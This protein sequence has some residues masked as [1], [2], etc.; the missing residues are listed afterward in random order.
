MHPGM[1]QPMAVP[2]QQQQQQPQRQPQPQYMMQQPPVMQMHQQQPPP[3]PMGNPVPMGLPIQSEA[4][5]SPSPQPPP[6][7]APQPPPMPSRVSSWTNNIQSVALTHAECPICFEPLCK[8]PIGVFLDASGAR[9][10]KHFYNLDAAREW[11]N[12]GSGCCPLTRKRIASVREVPDIRTDPEGW[13]GTVDL[14]G[15]GQ[16][17]RAEVLECFKA[18]LPV[19]PTALDEAASEPSWWAQWDTDGSGYVE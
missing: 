17:S 16:L 7:P 14:D 9:V 5:P 12:G 3:P 4:A 15:D 18:Q 11:L 10:S 6:A 13:F 19:D 2:L 8:G 1:Q